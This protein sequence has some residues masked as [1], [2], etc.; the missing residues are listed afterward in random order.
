M[1]SLLDNLVTLAYWML[2]AAQVIGAGLTSPLFSKLLIA[3]TAIQVY[4][5]AIRVVKDFDRR[6][7]T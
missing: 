1:Q 2:Q 4:R 5:A 3:F 6:R 7:Q